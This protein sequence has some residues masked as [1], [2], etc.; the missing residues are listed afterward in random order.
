L[1]KTKRELGRPVTLEDVISHSNSKHFGFASKNFYSEFL[2]LVHT[3]AYREELFDNLHKSDRRDNDKDLRF[4][5][6][7][8]SLNLGKELSPEQL[9]DILFHNHHTEESSLRVQK[10]FI[11]TAKGHLKHSTFYE[12]PTRELL[13]SK[14]KEW[15]RLVTRYNC[16]TR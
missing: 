13:R 10:G 2:A 5:L 16:S 7:K 1:L 15:S 3:L 12:I 4:Y 9:E 8:C 14:P 6:T 11:L